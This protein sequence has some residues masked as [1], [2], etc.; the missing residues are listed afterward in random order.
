[1]DVQDRYKTSIVMMILVHHI[2]DDK[3]MAMLLMV[4]WCR[5]EVVLRMF[6]V[7]GTHLG[8]EPR[9]AILRWGAARVRCI[10][11]LMHCWM[12]L[13][14]G[15]MH[16][17]LR[18]ELESVDRKSTWMQTIVLSRHKWCSVKTQC[19]QITVTRPEFSSRPILRI[20]PVQK[21]RCR[22]QSLF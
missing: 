15:T 2:G 20:F 5:R 6:V 22:S 18:I 21:F 19:M 1:M 4:A 14:N 10:C 3:D 9:D 11:A 13:G 17:R 8:K 7:R 16:Q 12:H